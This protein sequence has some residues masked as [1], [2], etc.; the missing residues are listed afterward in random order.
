LFKRGEN[1]G[2]TSRAA[3]RWRWPIRT[4][5]GIVGLAL[6]LLVVL[7]LRL[8]AGPLS[9]NI[10]SGTAESMVARVLP[11]GLDV[12]LGETSLSLDGFAPVLRFAP[13]TLTQGES[14]GRIAL[15]G[16]EVGFSPLWSFLGR[17]GAYVTLD[18]PR[19]QLTQELGQ[20]RLAEFEV[21][22]EDAGTVTVRVARTEAD[23]PRITITPE[24]LVF[25]DEA[26]RASI[27]SDNDWLV[28]NLEGLNRMLADF[29]REAAADSLARIRVRDGVLDMHD[30]V[31]G[32]F[33][34]FSA[35]DAEIWA[36]RGRVEVR[37]SAE[38]GGHTTE[39]ALSRRTGADGDTI[40]VTAEALDYSV[41]VPF[42]DD[43]SA[44]TALRGTGSLDATLSFAGDTGAV[45][46][47]AFEID[48]T[49]AD[50]RM[51]NDLFPIAMEPMRIDWSPAEALFSFSDAAVAI[52]ESRAIMDG[53]F[54][55]G[56]DARFGP[57]MGMSL[58]ARD[59]YLQPYDLGPPE[60]PFDEMVIEGWSTPLYSAVGID[61]MIVSRGDDVRIIGQGRLDTPREGLGLDFAISGSGATADDIKRLWPF[62]FAPDARGWVVDYLEEGRVTSA[63]MRFDF[64][65][66]SLAEDGEPLPEG[67]MAIEVAGDGV[68]IAQVDGM[69]PFAI[70]GGA[71]VSI[72]DNQV[73]FGFDRAT[74]P[75][76]A[77][78]ILIENAVFFNQDSS[79]PNQIYEVSGDVTGAIPALLTALDSEPI[80]LID[81]LGLGYDVAGLAGRLT[82]TSTTTIIGTLV[83]DD[84]GRMVDADYALNGTVT[85]LA[86]VQPVEG[87]DIADGAF[88]YT[89][90][91]EGFRITGNGL[92][93]DVPVTLSAVQS[94]GAAPDIQISSTL[95]IADAQR[96]GLDVSDYLSGS[97]AVEAWPLSDGTVRI[98]AD[99]ARTGLTLSDVGISKPVGQAGSLEAV[100]E[101]RADALAV[102]DLS[103]GFGDVRLA[104]ALEISPGG[105]LRSAD[106]STFRISPG[107]NARLALAPR[108]DG[109]SVTVRGT[110]LD[111][112]P[113]LQRFFN[114]GGATDAGASEELQDQVL[115][116]DAELERALGFFGTTA[117]NLDLALTLRGDDLRRANL[118]AQMG[119]SS[120]VSVTTNSTN[121][122]RT[123]TF[124]SNDVGT[125]LRFTGVYPRLLGGNGTMSVNIPTES[126]ANVG[127]FVLSDFAVF[128]E[129]NLSQ[130]IGTHS[131]SQQ[132]AAASQV[133]FDQAQG[134]FVQYEDVI[135]VTEISLFGDTVGG[136]LRGNI[137]TGAGQYDL[138]GTYVPLFGLNNAFA[139]IPILGPIFGGREG[140]GLLGVT[141]AVRGPL[142]DP[143]V[144]INPVSILAPGV[145]RGLFEFRSSRNGQ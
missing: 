128:G 116:V 92:V 88:F 142:N 18:R 24:G 95:D 63:H 103:L 76:G 13:V 91:Q 81:G 114:L 28:S 16:L 59:V 78:S 135:E 51:G 25:A 45:R 79:A 34:S 8:L 58:R 73:Q 106:F 82:G 42:L 10:L 61:R 80:D 22:E 27:M 97:V 133:S 112:K 7:Y 117:Y 48:L 33:R 23:D 98:S 29:S 105:A 50:L 96:L 71:Q 137:F 100:L 19:L 134:A 107:D 40:A 54:V 17:P 30:P 14:G 119:G 127:Y 144:L 75:A 44:L 102:S 110:Q 125:V 124:A 123:V 143:E 121:D 108:Q 62:V 12:H 39:I 4:V 31:Y 72:R 139:Q 111:I 84:T 67:S 26:A 101:L 52:G 35:L 55:M 85:D 36:E 41:V 113:V 122:G 136:T 9:L 53:A 132:I 11:T 77:D 74:L 115:V 70:D 129:E 83:M 1:V 2:V 94:N 49:G 141:F 64:P 140:E 6:L 37:A 57:T 87:F 86:T 131:E 47:G 66:G 93:Q 90:S 21:I 32:T 130:I 99:L 56:V 65:V 20:G 145:F 68:E 46:A 126:G 89:A 104:G 38:I 138:A 15:D 109:L 3:S 118:T 69:P 120:V 60:A 43:A 5:G